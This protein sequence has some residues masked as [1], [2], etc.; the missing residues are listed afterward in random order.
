MKKMITISAIA[1]MMTFAA[2][3]EEE[4]QKQIDT[5]EAQVKQLSEMQKKTR[6]E[7]EIYTKKAKQGQ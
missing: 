6:E 7:T 1:A 2:A 4:M 5:L 3:S